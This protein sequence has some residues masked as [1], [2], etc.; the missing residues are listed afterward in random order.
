MEKYI[1][2]S[3]P[4]NKK[5]D[6][7][8]KIIT[9]KLR[10]I[11]SFRFMN[12]SLED[13]VDNLSGR[14]FKSIVCTECMER[15]KINLECC[16][17]GL[18]NDQLIYRCREFKKEWGRSIKP[19]IRNFSSIYQFCNGDLNKFILLLKK[20]VYPYEDINNWEKFDKTILPPKEAFHSELK[21]ED[22]SDADYVHAENVWEVF[23]IKN[24]GE[25]HDLY[26]QSHTLLL[27][28]VFENFRNMCLEIYGIDP[29]YFVS[30]PGLAWQ[31][32]FKKTVKL[33]L[34]TGYDMLLMIEKGI[35]GGICRAAHRYAKANNKY[36]NNYD[37]KI[38]SSYMKYLD[39]NNLY[40]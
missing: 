13:L 27:A 32:C 14:I 17:V 21:L 9:Q 18:K 24:C 30:A 5:H 34:L 10:F 31:A 38:D 6:D 4:I 2:F 22:I 12:V 3:A 29:T 35:R 40:G 23:G 28:D 37:K 39:A 36:I 1:T 20:G 16:F 11:D 26:A 15:K 25:Y 19:L 33:E 8:G 7:D